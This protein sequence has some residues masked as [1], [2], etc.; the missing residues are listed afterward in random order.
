MENGE[1]RLENEKRLKNVTVVSEV[2]FGGFIR[3]LLY[4]FVSFVSFVDSFIDFV[5][6]SCF[7]VFIRVIRVIR[8]E[9]SFNLLNNRIE[10][11]KGFYKTKSQSC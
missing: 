3:V 7:I 2:P 9:R 10:Y 4:L 6:Y 8:G 11:E 1:W 5:F